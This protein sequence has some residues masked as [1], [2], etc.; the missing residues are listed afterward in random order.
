MKHLLALSLVIGLNGL[1]AAPVQAEQ[2]YMECS[3]GDYELHYSGRS[4]LDQRGQD[5]LR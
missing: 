1:T 4:W 2:R 3:S 5:P